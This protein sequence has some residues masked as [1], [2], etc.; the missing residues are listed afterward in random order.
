MVSLLRVAYNKL[1][2][3]EIFPQESSAFIGS[4]TLTIIFLY[5]IL[6][7]WVNCLPEL[8]H[9]FS[10]FTFDGDL[11]WDSMQVLE[12][13]E[14]APSPVTTS[15]GIR[16]RQS[17]RG[18]PGAEFKEMLFSGLSRWQPLERRPLDNEVP[19]ASPHPAL[20]SV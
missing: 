14:P 7:G 2:R 9:R 20:T 17:K 6:Q 11:S 3:N 16:T 12:K 15:S 1:E 8:N 19:P 13:A 10:L 4:S 18:S 5:F